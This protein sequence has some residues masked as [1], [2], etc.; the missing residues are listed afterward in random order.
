MTANSPFRNIPWINN[1]Q[2][3]VDSVVHDFVH[4]AEDFTNNFRPP[5]EA[6]RSR[7][8][9]SVPPRQAAVAESENQRAPP[10]STR[11]I[12]QLPTIRVAPEDLVD[13]NNREC[14]ICLEE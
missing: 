6:R 13:A 8:D 9:P 7:G 5:R 1:V 11:A 4:A 10:A 14:C 2:N 12:R 3:A